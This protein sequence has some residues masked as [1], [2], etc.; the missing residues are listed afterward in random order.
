MNQYGVGNCRNSL[1]KNEKSPE[2]ALS[3]L[4]RHPMTYYRALESEKSKQNFMQMISCGLDL[5]LTKNTKD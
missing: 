4:T 5:N 3:S 2:V 1:N